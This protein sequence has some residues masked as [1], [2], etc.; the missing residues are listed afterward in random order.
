MYSIAGMLSVLSRRRVAYWRARHQL[1]LDVVDPRS[2]AHR[3]QPL[4]R[5][6]G[7]DTFNSQAVYKNE[8]AC[9]PVFVL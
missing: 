9:I 4:S 6:Q 8:K 2:D 7:S 1:P 5:H 3:H